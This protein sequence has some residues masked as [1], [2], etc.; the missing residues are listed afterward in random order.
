MRRW[1]RKF[2]QVFAVI[3]LGALA[4]IP[5]RRLPP[6]RVTGPGASA[7]RIV[8]QNEAGSTVQ[9]TPLQVA[10]ASIGNPAGALVE[11]G[12]PKGAPAGVGLAEEPRTAS[13]RAV[14]ASR[15]DLPNWN[16]KLESNS[17]PP[18]LPD[19]FAPTDSSVPADSSESRF[20]N[21]IAPPEG[22]ASPGFG[23]GS[24]FGGGDKNGATSNSGT[25]PG[26]SS[27]PP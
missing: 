8:L 25:S 18:P 19:T 7:D 24:S 3:A 14:Q 4:A 12:V 5:F 16:S 23:G 9:E 1:L 15:K 17:P 6:P 27:S 22:S 13:N 10:P 21:P 20:A 2:I 26:F 11:G